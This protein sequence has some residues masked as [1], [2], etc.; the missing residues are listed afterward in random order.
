VIIIATQ[1]KKKYHGRDFIQ[2]LSN[3]AAAAAERDIWALGTLG[4][5]SA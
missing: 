3:A 2:S 1:S 5:L 4:F